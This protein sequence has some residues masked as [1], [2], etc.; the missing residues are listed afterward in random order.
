MFYYKDNRGNIHCLSKDDINNNG[1]SLLPK[2]CIEITEKEVNDLR[3]NKEAIDYSVLRASAYR[4]ESDPLFFMEQR[5][6]IPE[7][8]WLAKVNEIKA[9]WPA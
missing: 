1:L 2:S 8:T 9:R 4:E 7:G 5:G 3:A 6:E